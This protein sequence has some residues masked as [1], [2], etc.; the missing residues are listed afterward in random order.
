M[1]KGGKGGTN[2]EKDR[3]NDRER[4]GGAETET[5]TNV[6]VIQTDQLGIKAE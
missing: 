6:H 1:I 3:V 2:I 5:E 4:E